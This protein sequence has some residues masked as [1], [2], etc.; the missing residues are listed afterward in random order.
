MSELS[1]PETNGEGKVLCQ[2]CGKPFSIIT[3]GHLA[4]HNV[5]MSQ[6]KSRFPG[7]TLASNDFKAKQ[8]YVK[9]PIFK[10]EKVLTENKDEEIIELTDEIKDEVLVNVENKNKELKDEIYDF[11]DEV[12][13][14]EEPEI[15]EFE[16]LKGSSQDPIK[17]KKEEILNFLKQFYMNIQENFMIQKLSLTNHL[18]YEYI[19][20]FADPA[21]KVNVEF[22]KT[23]WHNQGTYID[24]QRN[25]KLS[26]DG[27]QIIEIHSKNPTFND[28][29]KAL[30][31]SI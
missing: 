7:V 14:N 22:P 25:L 4:K 18:E 21:L 8:K 19:T 9:S 2:I 23:F 24:L 3:G 12:L 20:D 17:N 10:K 15:E 27:W 29:E 31:S 6:Y 11:P 30:T 1:Y 13:V 26:E 5:T 16:V 28:I